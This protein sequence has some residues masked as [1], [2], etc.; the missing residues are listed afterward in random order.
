M[1]TS[2]FEIKYKLLRFTQ[3]VENMNSYLYTQHPPGPTLQ[4]PI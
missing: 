2:N 1:L 4:F 3:E